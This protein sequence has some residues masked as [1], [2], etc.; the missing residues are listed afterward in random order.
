MTFYVYVLRCA[1]DNLY[2]G[3]TNDLNRRFA[4]HSEGVNP[5]AYTFS[6]RPVTVLATFEF[7]TAIQAFR[8]ERMMKGWS[9]SKKLAFID[10][11][12]E[13]FKFLSLKPKDRKRKLRL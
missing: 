6:R 5:R 11:K 13:L 2:I 3:Y 12:V 8:A 7:P 1:D 10:E 4:E 9:R